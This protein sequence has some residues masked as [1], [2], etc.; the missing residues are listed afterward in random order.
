MDREAAGG[1]S[2]NLRR[3]RS[4]SA[5][6][7]PGITIV[8]RTIA[9][10]FVRGLLQRGYTVERAE[11]ESTLGYDA[12]DGSECSYSI[13]R[14]RMQVPYPGGDKFSFRA[15]AREVSM[16][17]APEPKPPRVSS[18]GCEQLTLI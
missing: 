17:I 10:E 7:S 12:C 16:P 6:V 9:L 11:Q 14:G 8:R 1:D 2:P 5:R 13:Q 15:L 3:K 18:V 4:R